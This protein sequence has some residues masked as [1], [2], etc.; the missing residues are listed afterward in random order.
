MTAKDHTSPL[1]IFA[2][3]CILAYLLAVILVPCVA[4]F[5]RPSVEAITAA[6]TPTVD[7]LRALR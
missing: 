2:I 6:P 5:W 1:I 4:C 3:A 7:I